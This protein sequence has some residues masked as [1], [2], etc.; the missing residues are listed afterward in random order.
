MNSIYRYLTQPVNL[1]RFSWPISG[2]PSPA[3]KPEAPLAPAD[4]PRAPAPVEAKPDVDVTVPAGESI[5]A[6]ANATSPPGL[7]TPALIIIAIL[8]SFVLG[9]MCR[10]L[11]MSR[12]DHGYLSA[13]Y[14]A[15]AH[16]EWSEFRK[17]LQVPFLDRYIILGIAGR[18]RQ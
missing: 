18:A 12:G 5:I 3:I 17:L 4:V 7:S 1:N 14:N 6:L 16:V 13:E 2:Y 9:F 15:D 10:T 11:V 8:L